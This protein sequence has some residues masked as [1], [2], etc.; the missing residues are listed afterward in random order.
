MSVTSEDILDICAGDWLMQQHASKQIGSLAGSVL[1]LRL[2]WIV[3]AADVYFLQYAECFLAM[4]VMGK[5]G[6]FMCI[7]ALHGRME[8]LGCLWVCVYSVCVTALVFL[9]AS[10]G[11]MCG[12]CFEQGCPYIALM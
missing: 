7:C 12:G 8:F 4:L 1:S 9:V 11:D 10:A 3:F 5:H 6:R 2:F